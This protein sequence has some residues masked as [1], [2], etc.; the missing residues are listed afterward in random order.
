MNLCACLGWAAVLATTTTAADSDGSSSSS[1]TALL[2]SFLRG[3][4]GREIPTTPTVVVVDNH[5]GISEFNTGDAS[6]DETDLDLDLH[7]G[8]NNDNN[9][10]NG[11]RGPRQQHLRSDSDA[12]RD[13]HGYYYNNRYHYNQQYSDGRSYTGFYDDGFYGDDGGYYNGGYYNDGYYNYGNVFRHR[14]RYGYGGYSSQVYR[15]NN[16]APYGYGPNYN[17]GRRYNYFVYI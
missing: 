14:N 17:Y 9:N 1:T 3:S 10:N 2:H 13:L 12:N 15:S 16:Y 5:R 7:E 6:Y 8:E 4:R 11:S